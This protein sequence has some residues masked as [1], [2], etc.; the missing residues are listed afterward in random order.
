[1]KQGSTVCT[2]SRLIYLPRQDMVC[3]RKRY[4]EN[5]N[6]KQDFRNS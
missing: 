3:G 1:M 4:T 5:G 2:T 6:K